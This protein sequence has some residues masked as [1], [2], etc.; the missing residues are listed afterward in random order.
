MAIWAK[1]IWL[2]TRPCC[3]ASVF[4]CHE[5]QYPCVYRA[6]LEGRWAS[7]SCCRLRDCGNR[8]AT[9][10][11]KSRR[12]ALH[13]A[14][15]RRIFLYQDDVQRNMSFNTAKGIR[16]LKG[17]RWFQTTDDG[18]VLNILNP[19]SLSRPCCARP[20]IG[21]STLLLFILLSD[22]S[23]LSAAFQYRVGSHVRSSK[24]PSVFIPPRPRRLAE[25]VAMKGQT[26]STQKDWKWSEYWWILKVTRSET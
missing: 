23:D 22:L 4:E 16:S 6:R 14:P 7:V 18:D 11:K 24:V 2:L 21:L 10:R 26:S 17:F 20:R 12:C 9:K 8:K 15:N 1:V 5:I 3:N 25:I 19:L 13:P